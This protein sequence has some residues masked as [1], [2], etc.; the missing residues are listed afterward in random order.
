MIARFQEGWPEA[1]ERVFKDHLKPDISPGKTRR[2]L[3]QVMRATG[4]HGPFCP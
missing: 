1:Y 4:T 2:A 3:L